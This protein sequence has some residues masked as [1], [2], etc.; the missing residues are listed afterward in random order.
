MGILEII[1]GI[2]CIVGILAALGFRLSAVA[3]KTAGKLFKVLDHKYENFTEK[4]IAA[5]VVT[6]GA[7][8]IIQLDKTTM[9]EDIFTVIKPEVDGLISHINATDLS[10]VKVKY[11]SKYFKNAVRMC[12]EFF[13]KRHQH[14]SHILN[15][16]DKER[17][18]TAFKEAILADITERMVNLQIGQI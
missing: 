2:F 17:F 15:E 12:E 10:D 4:L 18:Y 1:V 11:I 14:S 7:E 16:K 6:E 13:E 8:K 5:G 9:S 3:G